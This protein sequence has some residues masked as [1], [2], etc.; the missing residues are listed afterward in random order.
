MDYQETALP[1]RNPRSTDLEE[2]GMI[3]SNYDVIPY[4]SKWAVRRPDGLLRCVVKHKCLAESIA[5]ECTLEMAV[6]NPAI[7]CVE[8]GKVY[9]TAAQAAKDAGLAAASSITR[10]IDKGT[11]SGGYHWQRII[12]P[13]WFNGL[14]ADN[15]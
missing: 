7:I 13:D 8:T 14:A 9:T 11:R 5:K 3:G 2:P 6:A 15:G 10:A 4:G 1:P 12:D